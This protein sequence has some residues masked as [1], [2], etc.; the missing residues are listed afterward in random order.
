Y[1]HELLLAIEVDGPYHDAPDYQYYDRR[2]QNK[3]ESMG[4][5]F[6][7][8]RNDEVLNQL[9]SVIERINEWLKENLSSPFDGGG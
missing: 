5:S 2:R 7:R 8:F 4:V 1:C 6:L 9:D 3:L